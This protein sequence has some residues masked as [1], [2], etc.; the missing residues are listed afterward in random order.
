MTMTPEVRKGHP[1]G[2]VLDGLTAPADEDDGVPRASGP[3]GKPPA[4]HRR[5]SGPAVRRT[6]WVIGLS[7]L[8]GGL[9]ACVLVLTVPD[10]PKVLVAL[11]LGA[12]VLVA[13]GALAAARFE[14][15]LLVLVATRPLMDAVNPGGQD[16]LFA[17]STVVGLL[18]V[19]ASAAW[20]W[21]R[22]SAG[23]LG[24]PTL[25]TAGMAGLLVAA[26]ISCVV[27]PVPATSVAAWVR[28]LSVALMVV[29]LEQVIAKSEGMARRL[30]VAF[31]VSAFS[32]AV[33]TTVQLLIS[34]PLEQYTGLVRAQ[35]PFLHANVLAKYLVIV[36]LVLIG[37]AVVSQGM[38]RLVQVAAAVAA[39][40]LILSTQT[41][42]SWFAATICV[43][44]LIG[45]T[46]RWL[47]P[48][49][50][51]VVAVL[52][53]SPFVS[54]RLADLTAPEPLAGVPSNSLSWRI[55]YW[56]DLL[57]L[58]R[59]S[60]LNGTG[61]DT[62]TALGGQNLLAHNIWVQALVEMGVLG[63]AALIG[64]VLALVVTVRRIDRGNVAGRPA[65]A[66]TATAITLAVLTT[67]FSEN[68]LSETTTLWYTAIAI[69]IV[70]P[71]GRK[72]DTRPAPASD[73]GA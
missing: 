10:V 24:K 33:W 63:L 23:L 50:G 36:L 73:D 52:A 54:D 56:F 11:V 22:W 3:S 14:W 58:W 43:V 60:P 17:P 31:L 13:G 25:M 55:G 18:F 62:I 26:G 8:S 53:T 30:R 57:G 2:P 61:L 71:V 69:A 44:F 59:E 5:R 6:S 20:L 48:V 19:L 28:L 65:A 16:R 72:P 34:P 47:L 46:Y 39:F 68:L 42:I 21:R 41:R 4:R 9:L 67:S 29:V 32:V 12:V 35:G 7:A 38:G 49:L 66:G 40:A 45:R 37:M 64:A 51:V 15:F 1:A 27:S 70:S